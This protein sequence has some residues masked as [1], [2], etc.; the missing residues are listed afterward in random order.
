MPNPEITLTIEG[1]PPAQIALRTLSGS[2]VSIDDTLSVSGMAADAKAAGDLIRQ[3]AADMAA[4]LENVRDTYIA[5]KEILE[6]NP[7]AVFILNQSL[8]GLATLG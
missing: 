3:N 2:Q 7:D 8:L 1:Q 5:L 6:D 4:L